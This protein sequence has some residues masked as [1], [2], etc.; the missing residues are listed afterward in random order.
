MTPQ[1]AAD[2]LSALLLA[3][4]VTAPSAGIWFNSNAEPNYYINFILEGERVVWSEHAAF[5]KLIVLAEERIAKIPDRDERVRQ[6]FA[7]LLAA[8]TDYAK[9]KNLPDVLVNPLLEA[10]ERLSKNVLK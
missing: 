1:Q 3:K 8:A 5:E 2:H 9:E 7:T 4:G 10:M 6:R